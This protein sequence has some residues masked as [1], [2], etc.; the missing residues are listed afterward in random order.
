L[1]GKEMSGL[2]GG[3]FFQVS[4]IIA[5]FLLC[6]SVVLGVLSL[7]SMPT[8]GVEQTTLIDDSFTLTYT[9]YRRVGLGSFGSGENLTITAQCTAGCQKNF[10]IIAAN[11][12]YTT[13]SL[14]D[15]NYTFTTQAG[16]YEAFFLSNSTTPNTVHFQVSVEKNQT[17]K[18][19]AALNSPAKIMFLLSAV[20]FIVVTLKPAITQLS[21]DKTKI[22]LPT[23][24]KKGRR[25]LAL[26]V[27]LSTIVWL[28][29]LVFNSN[30]L[31][32][33]T[34]LYT[35]HPRHSYVASLFVKDGFSVFSMPLGQ[36]ASADSSPFKFVT[37]PEMSHLYPLGS[38]ALFLP[39]GEL[40]QT[41]V[42]SAL[43]Y[44][45]EI[46]IFLIV[47]NVCMY[48]FFKYFLKQDLDIVPKIISVL[49][50][51]WSLV[52]FAANG[53]FDAVAFIFSLPA[54]ILF[55]YKRYDA[56]FLLMAVSITLKYQAGIFLLPLIIIAII[57][58]LSENKLKDLLKNKFALAGFALM[59]LNCFTAC[60]SLPYFLET[61]AELSMNGL[62][63]FMSHQ[64][65]PWATQAFFVFLTLAI[66]LVFSVY[67]LKRNS[68]ISLSAIFL[69]IPAFT[70][71]F[72]QNW[73]MSFVFLYALIPQP[74]KDLTATV[75]WLAYIIFV[76]AFGGISF[77]F[78]M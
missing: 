45:L 30:P 8:D 68:L 36:L 50:M 46:G 31:G 76:I 10:T 66:T 26:L 73:Y 47:A 13:T 72:F 41:G 62:N 60:L 59:V 40:L 63:A 54:V 32:T 34:N 64:Q 1:S 74:K 7:Y 39:F 70:M 17:L 51:Y 55:L 49:I 69:L 28:V 77:S 9:E 23:L 43:V 35:D 15:I 12:T 19:L 24:G 57:K 75:L 29:V 20:L 48:L 27:F 5:L 52:Y 38:I 11:A 2:S 58:L 25:I 42:N 53:M 71:P 3:R 33:F 65:I 67:M 44:K 61:R 14:G 18:P 37:W 78:P 22:N 6:L 16:Y 4:V 56:F 21:K